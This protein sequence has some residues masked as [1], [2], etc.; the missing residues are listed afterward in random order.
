MVY[1]ELTID[2][3]EMLTRRDDSKKF[4]IREKNNEFYTYMYYQVVQNT[5]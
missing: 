2:N 5:T 1:N 3:K 4:I